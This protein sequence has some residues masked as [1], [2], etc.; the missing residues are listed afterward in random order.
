MPELT[1]Q[2]LKGYQIHEQI[3]AGGFGAVYKAYQPI[4]EREVAIKVI[5]AEYANQP[6]FIRRFEA[7]AQLIAR[8]EHSNI[9]P[10]YDYWRDPQGAYLV[11]RWLRG[12]SLTSALEENPYNPTEAAKLLDQ[13][14]AALAIA[15][16]N[17]VVHRDIKPDNILLDEDNNAYLTDFGIS[18]IVGH[19]PDDGEGVSGTIRYIAPEQL[20]EEPDAVTI[21]IYSLGIV[22]FEVLTGQHPFEEHTN[23]EIVMKHLTEPLPDLHDVRSDLP[24]ALSDVIHKAT[25]KES[26]DR[27]QSTQE[28]AVAFRQAVSPTSALDM[29]MAVDWKI[30]IS[31]FVNPFKG[32]RAFQEADASDFFGR[33]TLINSLIQALETNRF[34]TVIGP[35][36]SGKSSVVR[37]GLIPALRDGAIAGSENWF[38]TD[39]TPNDDPFEELATALLGITAS[40][41]IPLMQL[42]RSNSN[43]ISEAIKLSLPSPNSQLVLVIDQFEEVFTLV[44]SEDE[45]V[46]FLDGLLNAVN[47][48]DSCIRLIITMRADFY[49]RPLLYPAFGELV[50]SNMETVL[51]L[52]RTQLEEVISYPIVQ[53]GAIMEVGLVDIIIQDVEEQP[54][55]LPLLQYALTEL[56][57]RHEDGML[58]IA[59]YHD[60]GGV[61][62]ALARRAEEVFASLDT[63]LQ[64][65]A[66]QLFLR[67]VMLNENG[68]DTRRRVSREELTALD[69]QLLNQVLDAFG[70]ARLLTFDRDPTTRTPTVEVSHE[71]LIYRWGQLTEWIE[72]SR[73]DIRLHQRLIVETDEWLS[74]G[75]DAGFLVTD[76]RL[77]QYEAWSQQTDIV[78]NDNEQ[79]YLSQSLARRDEEQKRDEA[80]KA[81]EI[82]LQQNAF[83]RLQYLVAAMAVFLVVAVGLSVFALNQQTIAETARSTS[84]ANAIVAR[85][86]QDLAERRAEEAESFALSSQ[87]SLELR[88]HNTDLALAFALEANHMDNP[89]MLSKSTLME[90]AYAP[91][92]THRCELDSVEVAAIAFSPDGKQIITS[93]WDQLQPT[94]TLSLWNIETCERVAQTVL[95]ESVVTAITFLSEGQRAVY[96]T[97]NTTNQSSAT[98]GLWDVANWQS[99]DEQSAGFGYVLRLAVSSND[100]QVIVDNLQTGATVWTIDPL[101]QREGRAQP[102]YLSNFLSDNTRAVS[103][104]QRTAVLWDT[105]SGEALLS[106]D[107]PPDSPI[108][109]LNVSPDERY[110]VGSTNFAVLVLWDL[111][112]GEIIREFRG[113]G[114]EAIDVVFLSDSKHFLSASVDN[115]VRLWDIET[116]AEVYRFDGHTDATRDIQLLENQSEFVSWSKDNTVR[117]WNLYNANQI[118]RFNSHTAGVNGIAVSPDGKHFASGDIASGLI[119][120]ERNTGEIIHE[121]TDVNFIHRIRFSSDGKLMLTSA[122]NGLFLHDTETFE[123]IW[124]NPFAAFSDARFSDDDSFIVGTSFTDAAGGIWIIETETGNPINSVNNSSAVYSGA[125]ID[126]QTIVFGAGDKTCAWNFVSEE[127]GQCFDGHTAEVASVRISP[128][129]T[130]LLTASYDGT[131]KLWNIASGELILSFDGHSAPVQSAE[132]SP[133][134]QQILTASGDAS[135]RIWDAESGAEIRRI[136]WTAPIWTASFVDDSN[137]VLVGSEDGL[138]SL[139]DVT[140]PDTA[141][142]MDWVQNNRYVV[143]L[144]CDQL[145]QFEMDGDC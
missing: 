53:S 10:L 61:V 111:E 76:A 124:Q 140:I 72:N 143:E 129:A 84:D 18:T 70:Q 6:E 15:H 46:L 45:R 47:D 71:A 96:T 112:T 80:R 138:V 108:V 39:M 12:G 13:I 106:F 81:R 92:T 69:N 66:R 122:L 32:L 60:I 125:V 88:Q 20:R 30:D 21:D 99:I 43:G 38:I 83:R 78:L 115:S 64:G 77:E 55:V 90:V 97:L 29:D 51:P 14:S 40:P 110:V 89:P 28:M 4:I 127:L 128:D 134:G 49:D 23:A 145:A 85:E 3:G 79:L 56:F 75:Q 67:L 109:S 58:T 114:E 104:N 19:T 62:G 117:I 35:S 22:M 82:Q 17:H 24:Q 141:D 42:F 93:A 139:W 57:D 86:A 59:T 101:Q 87:A 121:F 50:R 68:N 2:T 103:A 7:E 120:W 137:T 100:E 48:S 102:Y 105:D 44:E 8:L 16:R 36:G 131:A 9:V 52:T 135:F 94:T 113:H 37:A 26:S 119:L 95:D 1:N 126:E 118:R 31:T 123:L 133:D 5:L 107:A 144:T 73:E 74:A 33:Q 130:K 34:I 136:N 25:A 27:Y 41:A 132:F 54:G 63:S 116:G 142:L 11:L 65:I 98:I 91:A